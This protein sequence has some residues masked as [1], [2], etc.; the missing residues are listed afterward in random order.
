MFI[1][2]NRAWVNIEI[3]CEM[4]KFSKSAYYEW[5]GNLEH[6]AKKQEQQLLLATKVV[7]EFN[8]SRCTYGATRLLVKL[9][10]QHITCSYKQVLEIM[11]VNDL[12]PVTCNKYKVTTNSNHKYKVF[13]NLLERNFNTTHPNQVWVGDITYIRTNEGWLYLATIIDLFSRKI[14]GYHMDSRMT[15]ESHRQN[16]SATFL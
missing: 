12:V 9:N 4:F 10:K 5:L 3:A 8:K 13:E 15:K 7:T 2:D 11:K 1:R 16:S 14:I 6:N